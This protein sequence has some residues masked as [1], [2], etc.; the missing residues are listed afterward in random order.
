MGQPTLRDS[1][2]PLN[3]RPLNTPSSTFQHAF[4]HIAFKHLRPRCVKCGPITKTR[5]GQPRS[6][7]M[8]TNLRG[9]SQSARLRPRQSVLGLRICQ[10]VQDFRNDSKCHC[11]SRPKL[12]A[13]KGGRSVQAIRGQPMNTNIAL[14]IREPRRRKQRLHTRAAFKSR[15]H[16]DLRCQAAQRSNPLFNRTCLLQAG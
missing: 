13:G 12:L 6:E 9:K 16:R 3:V 15:R 4:G 8:G 11:R 2:D 7:A 14:A 1:V 5:L 10:S